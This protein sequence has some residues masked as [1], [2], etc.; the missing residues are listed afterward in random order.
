MCDIKLARGTPS[1]SPRVVDFVKTA[2]PQLG[3]LK[4]VDLQLENDCVVN[5]NDVMSDSKMMV[6]DIECVDLSAEIDIV[7]LGAPESFEDNDKRKSAIKLSKTGWV[8]FSL[9]VFCFC[10]KTFCSFQIFLFIR[11]MYE[12][13][14]LLFCH[15]IFLPLKDTCNNANLFRIFLYSFKL[16]VV[17]LIQKPGILSKRIIRASSI[18]KS[19][20]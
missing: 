3:D 13:Y 2:L 11:F 9:N 5:T 8:T 4:D 18:G 12:L 15:S 20:V 6:D 1:R 19:I 16:V 10:P 17:Q 14:L 7:S